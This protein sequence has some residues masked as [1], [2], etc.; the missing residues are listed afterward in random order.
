QQP[1]LA[2]VG[3]R[4]ASVEGI[5][6]A[7]RF[8]RTLARAGFVITSGLAL[9]IDRAAHEGALRGCTTIAVLGHGPGPC[10]LKRNQALAA[11][12]VAGSGALVTEFQ[13]HCEPRREY[14]PQRNRLISGLS[15]ATIVVEAAEHSGSLITARCAAR[16][17]REVFAIPGSIHN[18]LSK[19]CHR[20]L[21]D[22]ANW[23]ESVD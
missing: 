13:P 17:G 16:Q 23:L 4:H 20:L 14:F 11:E 5:D 10:Y 1:Q 15:L 21:R 3:A 22:G 2:M 8:A 18:P 9:G 6:N 7:R 19:G 12:T